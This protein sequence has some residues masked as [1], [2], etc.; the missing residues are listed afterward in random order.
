[1]TDIEQAGELATACYFDDDGTGKT[2]IKSLTAFI[3]AAL[4]AEHKAGYAEG[5]LAAKGDLN[6]ILK[7]E[8]ERAI[9][10]CKAA[11]HAQDWRGALGRGP[12]IDD[13]LDALKERKNADAE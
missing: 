2:S 12:A 3:L 11:V 8:W 10:G 9:E 6:L 5:S 1:M 4:Q 7:R 13:A